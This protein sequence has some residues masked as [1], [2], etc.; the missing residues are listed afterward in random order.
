MDKKTIANEPK[1]LTL[2][3]LEDRPQGLSFPFGDGKG[4]GVSILGGVL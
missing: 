1:N 4:V 2:T 3:L